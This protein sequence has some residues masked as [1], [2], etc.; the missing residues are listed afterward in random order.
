MATQLDTAS[1]TPLPALVAL[2]TMEPTYGMSMNY[3]GDNAATKAFLF[4]FVFRYALLLSEG[5][6]DR[7]RRRHSQRGKVTNRV[8][9]L[10]R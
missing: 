1:M 3:G 7:D 4:S 8:T 6:V 9:E 2:R 10:P 5:L